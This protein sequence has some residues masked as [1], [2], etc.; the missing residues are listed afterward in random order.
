MKLSVFTAVALALLTCT[1]PLFAEDIT[2]FDANS[3]ISAGQTFD[4]VVVKGPDTVLKIDGATVTKLIVTDAA[5]VDMSA[6][7]IQEAYTYDQS[8][9]NATGGTLS[10]AEVFQ[11]STFILAGSANCVSIKA[12]EC[13]ARVIVD[14]PSAFS[15]GVSV[16]GARFEMRDGTVTGVNLF[17]G[18]IGDVHGG[19]I[20][21]LNA[22]RAGQAYLYGG[23]IDNLTAIYAEPGRFHV[24]GHDLSAV[25]YGGAHGRGQVEGFWNNDDAFVIPFNDT[26]VY[27]FL[28]LYDG[29]IPP[30]CVDQ[31]GADITGDCKVDL[32]DL[33]ELAGDWLKC[34]LANPDDCL[35]N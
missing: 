7:S 32:H 25:S 21:F 4:T 8:T 10:W 6:G 17:N 24:I 3:V 2:V 16:A 30:R 12:A 28:R 11:G 23:Q 29:V 35:A 19:H 34:G 33:A 20:E 14:G 15:G 1:A 26:A 22:E 9:L 13:C 27:A 31:P 5:R 18:G